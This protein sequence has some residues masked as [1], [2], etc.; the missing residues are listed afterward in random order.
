MDINVLLNSL[1]KEISKEI[2][3]N[4][5]FR[6]RIVQTIEKH[7]SVADK[8]KVQSHRRKPGLFDPMLVYR[9]EPGTLKLRLEELSIDELKDIVAEHGMDRTKLAMKWKGKDRLIEL[10]ITTVHS[11]SQKG[12]VFRTTTTTKNAESVQQKNQTDRE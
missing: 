11:R 2:Q 6:E 4:S 5:N 12:D 8:K 7:I 9:A 10:I 1:F 3:S